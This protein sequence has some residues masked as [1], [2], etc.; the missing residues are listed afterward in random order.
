MDNTAILIS[1]AGPSGLMIAAQLAILDIPFRIID[2]NE[3][4]TT[5]SRALVMHARSLEILDQMGI[6]GKAIRQG[7]KARAV[8]LIANGKRKL[9]F[10]LEGVGTGLTEFPYLLIL[11]QSKTERILN[12]FLA[13]HGKRVERK[14]ELIDFICSKQD[15]RANLRHPDGSIEDIKV[16]WL[17]GADGAHS[18]VRQHLNIP[19]EGRTYDQSLFV[20]DCEA[21][22][23]IPPNEMSL[24]F[25]NKTFAGFFPMT[26]G[27]Y[28]VIGLVPEELEGKNEINF[29]NIAKDFAARVKMNISLRNP[30]WISIYNSHHRTTT[31]FRKERCFLCGDAAHIHS[32]VGAQGMNTGL[33]DAYNLAW[34]LAFVCSGKAKV[35]L[36]ETYHDERITIARNLV[37][38]TDRAFR[39]VTSKSAGAMFVRLRIL[40]LALSIGVPILEKIKILRQLAFKTISET[41]ISYR[42]SEL[43]KQGPRSSFPKHAPKPGDRVPYIADKKNFDKTLHGTKFHLLLFTGENGQADIGNSLQKIQQEYPGVMEIKEIILS[44]QTQYLYKTFGVKI[45]GY[46]LVR[47]DAYIAYRCNSLEFGDFLTYLEQFFIRETIPSR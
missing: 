14:T 42:K 11:E 44:S 17:I 7:A 22:L 18:L 19:F 45:N 9:R 2:K 29:E 41:G 37:K 40:P 35:K 43:S 10:N 24:A 3:D 5:Q 38:T 16:D 15:V 23:Q 28:R 6:A 4:H 31:T 13:T 25:S 34:K 39:F 1:G 32:P 26:N 47:P 12:D 20:L 33:Q 27:R 8:N 36:L 46:Y 30:E 21:N